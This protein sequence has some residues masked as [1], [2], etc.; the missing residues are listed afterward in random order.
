MKCG[1]LRAMDCLRLPGCHAQRGREQVDL[2]CAI[3]VV[4]PPVAASISTKGEQT[5]HFLLDERL[6][7]VHL[8]IVLSLYQSDFTE[9]T[10]ANDLQRV[11]VLR[12]FTSTQESQ[13]V[14]LRF[15]H[16]VLLPLFAIVREFG[17]V[18]DE[19]KVL[20]SGVWLKMDQN[21]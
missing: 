18:Q 16:R 3:T 13:K 20:G 11:V 17:I 15:P 9:S 19:F 14:G 4:S 7:R 6:Q 2:S 5:Y 1:A 12:L 8:A 10:L 21:L